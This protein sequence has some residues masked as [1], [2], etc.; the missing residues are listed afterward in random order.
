[1]RGNGLL[2]VNTEPKSIT[3]VAMHR[4]FILGSLIGIMLTFGLA[5]CGKRGD[6]YRPS[7]IPAES[8]TETPAS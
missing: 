1:M 6:P 5:A 8:Q 3:G 4:T 7:D 2:L